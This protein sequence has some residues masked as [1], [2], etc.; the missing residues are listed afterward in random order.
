MG[1]SKESQPSSDK[2]SSP[3][4]LAKLYRNF[5]AIGAVVLGS[6]AILAPPAGAA[7]LGGLAGIDVLQAG[8]GE[9]ARRAAKKNR[10]KKSDKSH[11]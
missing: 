5:N 6:L 11:S 2:A 10:L 7:V 3:E 1:K 9:V 8:A 4:R